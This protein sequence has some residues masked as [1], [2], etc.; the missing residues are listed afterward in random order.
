MAQTS[1]AVSARVQLL[2]PGQLTPNP[3]NPRL[4]FRQEDIDALQASIKEQGILVPLTVYEDRKKFV[5]L[6]GERRW[7]CALKLG[8]SKVPTIVQPKPD[9]LTN[10]MMMFAIHNARKDWDPMPTAYKLG[11]LESVYEARNGRRPTEAELAGL[12]SLSRGE[13]RRLKNLLDLPQSYRNELMAEL[14]K[15]RNEQAISVDHVLEATRG[16]AALQKRGI[17]TPNEANQLSRAIIHKF[18]TKV[19][20]NTVDP[21]QL[22][23]I[24]RAVDREE[25]DQRLAHHIVSRIIRE[26][27][28]SISNAYQESVEKADFEHAIEQLAGRLIANLKEHESRKYEVGPTLRNALSDV[29]R[30]IQRFLR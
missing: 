6:D 25:V 20:K 5:L 21:R 14:E 19:I 1:S 10:I 30:V 18:R 27:N 15:P 12:A 29:R 9:L 17:I 24:A 26:P 8:L 7:R 28:Y 23:R 2:D 4:I 22:A 13:V 3:E 16:A 11:Q